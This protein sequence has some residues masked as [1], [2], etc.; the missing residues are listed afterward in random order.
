VSDRVIAAYRQSALTGPLEVPATPP[1]HV[2]EYEILG[3]LGRGGMGVVY[4]ARHTQLH[5][6]AALKMLLAGTFADR[7]ERLRFRAEA[8]AV[9]RLHHPHIVQIYE[10]GEYDVGAGPP[11]PYFTLEFVDGGNLAARLAGRPQ[12]PRQVAAWLEALARAAHYAHQQGIVHRDLKPSNI[13]LTAKGQPKI[14]DFGVAKLLT[15]SDV[16]T[17]SGTLLGTA[18]Y[19][20]PEQASGAA[21]VGPAADVYALGAMLYAALTGRPP[22]Q[23]TSALHTLEQVRQQEPVPPRLLQP[24]VPRDLNTICLRCLEKDPARRYATAEALA[25]DLARFLAGE[26]IVARPVGRL[27]RVS[28]WV[29]RR[30]ALAA[31]LLTL[32][33]GTAT[34]VALVIGLWRG[35]VAQAEAERRAHDVETEARRE[36]TRLLASALLDQGL[37]LCGRGDVQYGLLHLT[38]GLELAA[39]VGDGR[40][41]HVA[42]VNLAAWRY[43]L[44]SERA[45]LVHHSWAWAVAFSPD[46]RMALTGGYD[47]VAHRWD[48]RTGRAIGKPLRHAYPVWAVAFSPDGRRFASGS[49]DE[50]THQ[51]EARLWDTATGRPLGPP[52]PQADA[53]HAVE[54]SRDGRRLLTVCDAEVRVWDVAGGLPTSVPLP[55]PVPRHKMPGLIPRLTGTFNPDGQT[56]LTG[57]EDGTARL[58]DAVTGEPKGQPLRHGGPVLALAFSPDGRSVLTGS[59]DRTARLWDVR[60]GRQKGPVLRHFGRVRAVAFSPDGTFLATGGA[61]EDDSPEPGM[62]R[63]VGGEAR[64]WEATTGNLLGEPLWHAGPV[65]ALAFRPGG[66]MLLTGSI[67]MAARFF[68]VPDGTL[69]G[70]PLEHEGSVTTVAFSPDGKRALTSSAGGGREVAARLWELPPERP[71]AAPGFTRAEGGGLTVPVAFTPDVRTMFTVAPGGRTVGKQDV[72]SGKPIGPTLVQPAPLTAVALS[73]DGRILLTAG[74]DRMVRWW[75][76]AKVRLLGACPV[77]E[78]VLG[79]AFSGD[80]RVAATFSADRSVRLWQ[81]PTGR[82]LGP[83]L[84][85]PAA[86]TGVA[87]DNSGQTVL[88]NSRD[89]QVRLWLG[90]TGQLAHTWKPPGH[91]V[92][93]GFAAGQPVTVTGDQGGAVQVWNVRTGASIGAPLA[94]PMGTIRA[95]AFSPDGQTLV[96]GSWER[97]VAQLWD[98]ATGK[99]LGPPLRHNNRIVQVAFSADGRRV[100][101]ASNGGQVQRSDVPKPLRGKPERVRCWLELL[102]GLRLDAQHKVRK[103]DAA[104]LVQCR[105]R[106]RELGGP[107]APNS[108]P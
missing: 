68:A 37:A 18:E 32:V 23:G 26:P 104:A 103:L 82:A 22:F 2:G 16:K 65:R 78:P 8:E 33:L 13:L 42:R 51:G 77:P 60:T 12:Q 43:Q 84:K 4:K 101:S 39:E 80:G 14:C 102:T 90:R 6:T 41:E 15:G 46:G 9:A 19:M 91:V 81:V 17:L 11:R 34:G 75:D 106:L 1:E 73:P 95:L 49:G 50:G 10:I 38:R 70:R 69:L 44:F 79:A 108:G 107:P 72:A 53:V 59:F 5:R 64:L 94:E 55:H 28:K 76:L 45:R 85:H 86:V 96:T 36:N 61:V 24:G 29:K 27:E 93:I 62:R 20:A 31:L 87:L 97:Q 3:E 88:T 83:G 99:P 58:W 98:L 71:L 57:G 54:F 74:T 105:Q 47:H 48:T 66:R 25:D 40:L 92:F 21:H 100:A 35:A 63:T 67:D 89:G 52:L 30:P 56:V 7:D